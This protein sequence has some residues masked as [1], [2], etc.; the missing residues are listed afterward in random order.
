MERWKSFERERDNSWSQGKFNS[1][2][3]AYCTQV[4]ALLGQDGFI[5][6]LIPCSIA[7]HIARPLVTDPER[8]YPP[9]F[10]PLQE[11]KKKPIPS[12]LQEASLP[13]ATS[14]PTQRHSL[15]SETS[16]YV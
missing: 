8:S 14:R 7:V 10:S 1:I 3:V 16:T 9:A 6:N 11:K 15:S 4:N 5:P 13:A 12:P 2:A